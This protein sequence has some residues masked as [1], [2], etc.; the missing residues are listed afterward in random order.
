MPEK[1]VSDGEVSNEPGAA[2]RRNGPQQAGGSTHTNQNQDEQQ[3]IGG[4]GAA[5]GAGTPG[6]QTDRDRSA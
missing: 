1:I 2:A 4:P 6:T 5:D 3:G